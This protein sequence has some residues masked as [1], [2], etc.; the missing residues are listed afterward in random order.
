M[1]DAGTC[2]WNTPA[3]A[4]RAVAYH[5]GRAAAAGG[6]TDAA[7]GAGRRTFGSME[8]EAM[9]ARMLKWLG[10]HAFESPPM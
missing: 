10:G 6:T 9:Q 2:I 7:D 1:A 5:R 3:S 4:V 8:R